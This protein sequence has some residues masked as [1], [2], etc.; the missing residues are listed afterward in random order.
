MLISSQGHWVAW[1]LLQYEYEATFRLLYLMATIIPIPAL[2][3]NY[4]WLIQE[5]KAV[6]IIDPGEATPV[7]EVLQERRLA[8]IAILVTHY[9][10]DHVNG[11]QELLSHYSVPVYGPASESIPHRTYGLREGDE[12]QLPGA[13]FQILDVPGHT[14]G[15][16][17][18]Y[19]ED[20]LLSGDTL[21]TAGC[22]RLFEGTA[23]QM[24]DSLAKLAS[25]A[26]AT[27]LYCGH[28]YTVA[29]LAFA[30]AVEPDNPHIQ[31]R[32]R[33]AQEKRRRGLSTVPS[34]LAIERLTNPFLRCDEPSVWSAAECYAGQPLDSAVEIFAT[35]RLWK[36]CF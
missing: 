14:A 20:L 35:L 16:I 18:Y 5:A 1:C 34:T 26:E 36:N 13:R 22:G 30:S 27:Q 11:I 7:L 32:L 10:W 25:L 6:A 17:A 33:E 29:N 12:V 21:F 15:A 24:Y 8:P 31:A 9:H 28:E 2:K 23:Q 4:I 19:G 3:D